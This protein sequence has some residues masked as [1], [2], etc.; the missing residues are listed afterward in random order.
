M[1][2]CEI[3]LSSSQGFIGLEERLESSAD[4]V[5][6]N[7]GKVYVFQGSFGSC[8]M[9]RVVDIYSGEEI[10]AGVSSESL[11][12]FGLTWPMPRKLIKLLRE[13]HAKPTDSSI[14]YLADGSTKQLAVPD[15]Y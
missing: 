2:T 9:V 12:R 1:D 10:S 7:L 4:R 13:Y 11:S 15:T 8:S 14:L 6:D 3:P 5:E